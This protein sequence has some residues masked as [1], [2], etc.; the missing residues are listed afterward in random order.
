MP[1]SAPTA[2]LQQCRYK[3]GKTLGAGSY[4]VVKEVVHIDTNRYYAAKVI[5]KRLMVGREHFVSQINYGK[6][7]QYLLTAFDRCTMK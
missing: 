1:E 5:N 4:S 3:I 7:V 6:G 2:T